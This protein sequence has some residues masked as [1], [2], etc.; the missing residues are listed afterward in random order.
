MDP[1]QQIK[2]LEEALQQAQADIGRIKK[3]HEQELSMRVTKIEQQLAKTPTYSV[4]ISVLIL[5][6]V[7]IFIGLR[8]MSPHHGHRYISDTDWGRKSDENGDDFAQDS[9]HQPDPNMIIDRIFHLI[10]KG[11]QMEANKEETQQPKQ[12]SR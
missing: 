3:A 10:E 2:Q 5:F 8:M 11:M 6:A 1:Q 4:F 7:V 12:P 9:D